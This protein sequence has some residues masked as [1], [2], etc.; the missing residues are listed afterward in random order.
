MIADG[1]HI[2]EHWRNYTDR[3][4]NKYL[5]KNMTLSRFAY[6]NSNMECAVNALSPAY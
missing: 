3:G 4:D 6:Q 2:A 5:E 1:R